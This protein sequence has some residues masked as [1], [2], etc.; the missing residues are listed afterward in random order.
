MLET[1]SAVKQY[2]D[3]S[4]LSNSSMQSGTESVCLFT[5]KENVW[6]DFTSLLVLHTREYGARKINHVHAFL[7]LSRGFIRNFKAMY[8]PVSL[9]HTLHSIWGSN[10]L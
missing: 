10:S 5:N 4:D 7:R 9:P 3:D 8:V 1:T 6:W 2:V